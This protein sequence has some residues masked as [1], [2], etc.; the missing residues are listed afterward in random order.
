MDKRGANLEELKFKCVID[1]KEEIPK[2][3]IEKF[4]PDYT[5]VHT[6]SKKMVLMAKELKN[7]HND[8]FCSIP[9]CDTVE[10]QALGGDIKLGDLKTGPRV[11]NYVYSSLEE[12]LEHGS[13][14]ITKG[15][16]KEVLR[17]TKLLAEENEI[18]AVNVEGPITI[19]TSLIDSTIF[20]K[21][22]RKDKENFNLVLD[23]LENEIVK[24][25]KHAIESGAKIISYSDSV[26]TIDIVGPKVYKEVSAKLTC[27]IIKRVKPYLK[28]CILHLCGK[29]SVS[30]HNLNFINSEAI[31]MKSNIL[32]EDALKSLLKE[33]PTEMIVGHNCLKRV[34]KPLKNNILWKLNFI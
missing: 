26:G 20:Y 22:M 12:L 5:S 15:R 33:N 27:N 29:T 10:A 8:F 16:I 21:A 9:F 13:I 11:R 3:I 28:G 7:Y 14:D 32:Y 18:V 34:K 31:E 2:E 30:L 4:L 25:I 17:A 1:L 6:D 24:Y 19:I 23:F